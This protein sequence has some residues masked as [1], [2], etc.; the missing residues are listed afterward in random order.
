MK[1][2]LFAVAVLSFAAGCSNP[3][4]SNLTAANQNSMTPRPPGEGTYVPTP[5]PDDGAPRIS[6][7][8]AKKDFD[9]GTAVFIDTHAAEQF[10]RQRI[11]GAI[12]ISASDLAAKEDKVPKGKKI[13]AYCS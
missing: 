2:I 7:A 10:S 9:A 13:I 4:G 8:D 11:P 3:G 5:R 12:N 1:G 6:V